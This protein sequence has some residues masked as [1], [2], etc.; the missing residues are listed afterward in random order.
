MIIEEDASEFIAVQGIKNPLS[1]LDIFP[2]GPRARNH[3][4][5][6]RIKCFDGQFRFSRKARL[7]L[8]K[9]LLKLLSF[10]NNGLIDRLSEKTIKLQIKFLLFG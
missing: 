6:K 2:G 10:L 7:E 4:S 3:E 5:S 8:K 9:A 1:S